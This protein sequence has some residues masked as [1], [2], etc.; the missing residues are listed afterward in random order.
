MIEALRCFAGHPISVGAYTAVRQPWRRWQRCNGYIH[1]LTEIASVG[2]FGA[3]GRRKAADGEALPFG[4]GRESS[5][6]L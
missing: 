1:R 4:F 5:I 2:E 3:L 6:V